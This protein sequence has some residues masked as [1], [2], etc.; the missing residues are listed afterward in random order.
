MHTEGL[1]DARELWLGGEVGQALFSFGCQL[2]NK[3]R[4]SRGCGDDV[5]GTTDTTPKAEVAG[6]RVDI[7]PSTMGGRVGCWWA[8]EDTPLKVRIITVK[9]LLHGGNGCFDLVLGHPHFPCFMV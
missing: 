4:H 1:R 6:A 8:R 7:D 9:D 5:P 3:R 2:G